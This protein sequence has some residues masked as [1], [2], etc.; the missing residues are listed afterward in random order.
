MKTDIIV[1]EAVVDKAGENVLAGVVLHVGEAAGKVYS[2][3]NR[4]PGGKQF[5]VTA[6]VQ[7]CVPDHITF[8]LNI[9]H[10]ASV[11][12][13]C[14]GRLSAFFRK[15]E[16]PVQNNFPGDGFFLLFLSLL[17]CFY[18]S[19]R[20]EHSRRKVFGVGILVKQFDCFRNCM[21]KTKPSKF[22]AILRP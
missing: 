9:D 13:A 22:M 4:L 15:K 21:H 20:G 12:D 14:V 2:A 8:K 1:A 7:H 11:Q 10:R 18:D 5:P 6:V 17:F 19:L 16:G 3:G